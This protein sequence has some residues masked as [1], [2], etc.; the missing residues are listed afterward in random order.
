MGERR[1]TATD[2]TVPIGITRSPLDAHTAW[3]G[4]RFTSALLDLH[5]DL[6]FTSCN[7]TESAARRRCTITF[8]MTRRAAA[9]FFATLAGPGPCSILGPDGRRHGSPASRGSRLRREA[10]GYTR[11][12]QRNPATS[13]GDA[14]DFNF[15]GAI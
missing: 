6:R 13:A 12:N 4:G 10:Q 9:L 1:V 3:R 11:A 2:R 7:G 15:L 5:I 14:R 8:S